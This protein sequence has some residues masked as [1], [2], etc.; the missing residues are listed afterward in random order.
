MQ[1]NISVNFVSS[2]LLRLR[3]KAGTIAASIIETGD[4]TASK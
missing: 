4:D 1:T 2:A 3:Y